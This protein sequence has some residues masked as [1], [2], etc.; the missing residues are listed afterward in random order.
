MC[1]ELKITNPLEGHKTLTQTDLHLTYSACLLSFQFDHPFVDICVKLQL[2][3]THILKLPKQT[4]INRD[5]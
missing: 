3:Y 4:H 5:N 1:S 2:P